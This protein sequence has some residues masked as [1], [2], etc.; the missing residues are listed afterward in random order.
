MNETM[1]K[2][3]KEKYLQ[4]VEDFFRLRKEHFGLESAVTTNDD[5]E[6]ED[7]LIYPLGQLVTVSGGRYRNQIFL[8]YNTGRLLEFLT[9]YFRN[10][11]VSGMG[12]PY[13][14]NLSKEQRFDFI[15][16]YAVLYP[17][18]KDIFFRRYTYHNEALNSIKAEIEQHINKKLKYKVVEVGDILAEEGLP[19]LAIANILN[20]TYHTDGALGLHETMRLLESRMG[21]DE[22]PRFKDAQ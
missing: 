18:Y 19:N 16:D 17:E 15:S 4:M 8:E 13:I 6:P 9:D 20:Q 12:D 10:V 21:A 5:D 7:V 1:A 22:N 14:D 11:S 2:K 3:E